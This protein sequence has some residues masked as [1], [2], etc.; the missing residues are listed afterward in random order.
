M[1]ARI[2]IKRS[3]LVDQG[4]QSE[5][6]IARQQEEDA[7]PGAESQVKAPEEQRQEE[8]VKLWFAEKGDGAEEDIQRGIDLLDRGV[9]GL[10]AGRPA[11]ASDVVLARSAL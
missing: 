2:K 4:L 1:Q 6:Q 10:L 9:Q 3:W 7:Y 5:V 11:L 8:K